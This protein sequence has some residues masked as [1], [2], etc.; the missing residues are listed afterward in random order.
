MSSSIFIPHNKK[1]AK[2][3]HNDLD[4]KLTYTSIMETIPPWHEKKPRND[5]AKK[6]LTEWRWRFLEFNGKLVVEISCQTSGN[7]KREYLNKYEKWV[8]R[9]VDPIFDQFVKEVYY[10]YGAE[11]SIL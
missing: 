11:N 10:Y 4:N 1:E 6:G 2:D 5:W 3:K 9:D 7:P 8:E